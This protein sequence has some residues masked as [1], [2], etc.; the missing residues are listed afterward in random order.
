ML[1]GNAGTKALMLSRAY[2]TAWAPRNSLSRL[3]AIAVRELRTREPELNLL[4]TYLNPG[5]GFDGAS[6]KA[7][8]WHLF[9]YEHGTRYAY[10]DAD[11][12]TDRD[13][14]RSFGTSDTRKLE[15]ML[16]DRISFSRMPLPPLELYAFG[17]HSRLNASLHDAE[18]H[19]WLRPWR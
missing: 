15:Q 1:P 7:A 12:V 3:I 13:L 16:G 17:L 8:N 18:P 9:G 4:F 10:L 11:Y 19:I 6:Y 14:T 2:A 5:I